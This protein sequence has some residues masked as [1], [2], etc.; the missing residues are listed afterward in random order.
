MGERA[1]KK[2][3]SFNIQCQ[4]P[5]P[6][7]IQSDPTRLKQIILNLCGNAIK[8]TEKGE[9]TLALSYDKPNNKICFSVKDSG[10]GMSTTQADELFQPFK[11]A[12]AST[13]RKYGGTGLGLYIS[14]QLTECLGGEL[15]LN[16]PSDVGSQFNVIIDAGNQR[17]N[18][19]L[20]SEKDTTNS[21]QKT[22]SAL[23]IPS[24]CGKVILADD[25]PDNQALIAIQDRK[26]VV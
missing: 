15:S 19:W 5:L 25:T 17:N 26:S 24:L 23:S 11:Q 13:T 9:I 2:G 21:T 12:D 16:R 4:F 20:N 14:K 8:F 18:D 6:K 3:L 7:I 1:R 10:I 22:P